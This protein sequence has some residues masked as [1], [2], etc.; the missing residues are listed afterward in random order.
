[1]SKKTVINI[2]SQLLLRIHVR[3]NA[4]QN[5][6]REI[7]NDQQIRIDVAADAQNG[8]ANEELVDYL[9]TILKISSNQID[10]VHGHRNREKL[11]R[12][13]TENVEQNTLLFDRLRNEMSSG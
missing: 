7:T 2:G 8:K 3:P 11:V 1:M 12:I 5:A 9:K 6:I 4:K 10:I 13:T